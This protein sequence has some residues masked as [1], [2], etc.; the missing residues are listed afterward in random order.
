MTAIRM[1]IDQA[2][3]QRK[4]ALKLITIIETEVSLLLGLIMFTDVVALNSTLAS[5]ILQNDFKHCLNYGVVISSY[6]VSTLGIAIGLI[7]ILDEVSL[8]RF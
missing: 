7:R 1:N 6:L 5:F 4:E 3:N 8:K 2:W